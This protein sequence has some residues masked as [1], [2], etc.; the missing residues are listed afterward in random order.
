MDSIVRRARLCLGGVR[1]ESGPSRPICPGGDRVAGLRRGER[2]VE[3]TNERRC[4]GSAATP[5][6]TISRHNLLLLTL[7]IVMC[8]EGEQQRSAQPGVTIQRHRWLRASSEQRPCCFALSMN[9]PLTHSC[10][11]HSIAANSLLHAIRF[12][13]LNQYSVDDYIPF[14]SPSL[15]SRTR[16]TPHLCSETG[17]WNRSKLRVADSFQVKSLKPA[18]S[19]ARPCTEE[20]DEASEE[21]IRERG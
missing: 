15:S 3:R 5:T 19:D 2:T 11:S 21:N 6:D 4:T 13:Q 1:G 12:S 10:T 20:I 14:I 18:S 16:S 17:R 9:L 8:R 7:C